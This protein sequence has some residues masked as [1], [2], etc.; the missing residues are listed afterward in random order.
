MRALRIK[1]LVRL[2]DGVRRELAQPIATARQEELR[3]HIA[4]AIKQVDQIVARHGTTVEALPTPT[5]RA[6]EFLAGLNL[7]SVASK[8]PADTDNLP[9]DS[10]AL[11]G[12]KSFWNRI[13]DGLAQP[14]TIEQATRA[15]DSIR[16]TS[17][18]VERH[19]QEHD[20]SGRELTSQTGAARGWL[21]F[22]GDRENFDAYVAAMD[23]VRPI[24]EAALLG[25]PRFV[26][27]VIV[28]FRP[29]SG[30]YRLRGYHTATRVTLPTPMITFSA[31]VFESLAH[32]IFQ[33]GRSKQCVLDAT[34]TDDYQSVQAEL[35]SLCGVVERPV[36]MYRD[37]AAS[38]ERVNREYFGSALARPRLTWS[39]T[40]AGRKFGHYDPIRD[41]VMISATLDREDLPEYA[42]DFVVYHEL[43]HKQLGINWR[44][45]RMN[46]HTPEFRAAERRFVRHVDADATLTRLDC[47][48]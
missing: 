26:S 34:A 45:G 36:G 33:A 25:A 35:E 11:V 32:M 16:A 9:E 23:R 10:V 24:M 47:G 2:A 3:G 12:L 28:H 37:L 30:L 20:F 19:L 44:Q 13:L 7:E 38:F 5:R 21:A 42:L 40:F 31:E 48:G 46:A 39:R 18:N 41:T 4:D 27:P 14:L 15:F 8:A 6:Y 1:G 29:T 17:E 43:L 22:F